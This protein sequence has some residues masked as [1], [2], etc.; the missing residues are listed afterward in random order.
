MTPE[1][2]AER[3]AALLPAA[4]TGVASGRATVEVVRQEWEEAATA[5][6]DDARLAASC[7]DLLTAV[8]HLDEGFEVVLHLWSLVERASVLL[9]T[10]CPRTDARVPSLARV[11]A[12]ADWHERETAEM[13]GLEFE[14][15]PGLA[16]LLLPPGFAGAP[17]R[18]DFV[19]ASR[20]ARPWP[21]GEEPGQTQPARGRRRV[22]PPG[23]P[24]PG[25]W[26]TGDPT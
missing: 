26:T 19:L 25:T 18:K 15:H 6:R 9:S 7:F 5:L 16:P 20:V 1:Q 23:V 22:Q 8:D 2:V 3:A 14:G 13:F 21:G 17:L 24:R 4:R 10:R 11:F 12:G